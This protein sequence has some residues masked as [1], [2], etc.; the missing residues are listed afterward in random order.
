MRSR[1]ARVMMTLMRNGRDRRSENPFRGETIKA[2]RAALIDGKQLAAVCRI[3]ALR[4]LH[5]CALAVS[6]CGRAERLTTPADF[7]R[8]IAEEIEKWDKVVEFSGIKIKAK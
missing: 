1:T 2:S 3:K 8:F 6:D 5:C 7:G 4:R